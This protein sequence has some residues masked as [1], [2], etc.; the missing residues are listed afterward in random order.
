MDKGVAAAN[1]PTSQ[2]PIVLR[3]NAVSRMVRLMGAHR[4]AP[5][6]GRLPAEAVQDCHLGIQRAKNSLRTSIIGKLLAGRGVDDRAFTHIAFLRFK[7]RLASRPG[8]RT[9]GARPCHTSKGWPRCCWRDRDR[10]ELRVKPTEHERRF[11]L[12]ADKR[13]TAF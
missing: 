2:A 11:V 12:V 13:L 1:R 9:R 8:C 3:P 5:L 6:I 4:T 10:S 7:G